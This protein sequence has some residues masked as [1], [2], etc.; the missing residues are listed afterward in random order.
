MIMVSIVYIKEISR[1][2]WFIHIVHFQHTA[3]LVDKLTLED[4]HNY[5]VQIYPDSNHAI[6]HHNANKNVYYL[7]TEYLLER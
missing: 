4:I 1:N 3:V 7:L 2:S 5:R 6:K